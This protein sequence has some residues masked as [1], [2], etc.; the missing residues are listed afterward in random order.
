MATILVAGAKPTSPRHRRLSLRRGRPA[1]GP[2]PEPPR[3]QPQTTAVKEAVE[4][5]LW[6]D[7]GTRTSYMPCK[8]F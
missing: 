2:R 7:I 1:A 3:P 5:L 8:R 6:T 4:L